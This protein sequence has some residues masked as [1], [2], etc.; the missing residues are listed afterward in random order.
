MGPTAE[1]TG[2]SYVDLYH[3]ASSSFLYFL[4]FG[5]I[6]SFFIPFNFFEYKITRFCYFISAFYI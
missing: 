5:K 2:V 6:K 4:G 3:K 1:W